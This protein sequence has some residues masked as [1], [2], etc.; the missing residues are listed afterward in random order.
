VVTSSVLIIAVDFLI[1][2]VLL[3]V[4]PS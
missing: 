1:T 2:H 3:S 4:F